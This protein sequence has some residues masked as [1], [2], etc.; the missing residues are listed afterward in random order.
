MVSGVPKL[1]VP[2]RPQTT[3]HHTQWGTIMKLRHILLAT[4]ALLP[5]ATSAFAADLPS[6]KGPAYAPTPPVFSWTGL[7]VGGQVGYQWTTSGAG[8]QFF[9]ATGGATPDYANY[10]SA[11]VIGGGKLGYN[12]QFT[13]FVLGIE[14][15]VEGSTFYGSGP[16]AGGNYRFLTEINVQGS[17]RGRLG[18]ACNQALFYATGGVAF[19]SMRDS[20]QSYIG[21]LGRDE[22]TSGRTGWTVGGGFEYFFRPNWTINAEY[23]YTDLGTHS[24][25]LTASTGGT[26]GD[27]RHETLNSARFGVAYHFS[28]FA[29]PVPVLAKY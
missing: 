20:Y 7:Y 6:R 9:T 27:R 12:W 15:D 4:A 8:S 5:T 22:T 26:V 2:A 18:Y 11:G 14:G 25:I 23:R 19:A 13:Q 16:Y 24:D 17:V 1:F 29:P 21:A 3:C 28:M 10:N